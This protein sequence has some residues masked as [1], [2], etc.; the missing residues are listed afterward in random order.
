MTLFLPKK[1]KNTFFWKEKIAK[2]LP[3]VD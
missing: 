3:E 2:L 1:S